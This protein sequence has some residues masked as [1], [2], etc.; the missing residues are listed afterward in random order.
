MRRAN[1]EIVGSRLSNTSG[2][3]YFARHKFG[4]EVVD[5]SLHGHALLKNPKAEKSDTAAVGGVEVHV[6]RSYC[7]DRDGSGPYELPMRI[8]TLGCNAYCPCRRHKPGKGPHAK[9]QFRPRR[10][11]SLFWIRRPP[12]DYQKVFAFRSVSKTKAT[13]EIARQPTSNGQDRKPRAEDFLQR[14]ERTPLRFFESKG[15]IVILRVAATSSTS[16]T[17]TTCQE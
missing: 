12:S 6:L 11:G 5:H 10:S 9:G 13:R 1:I 14:E 3:N 16:S 4:G 7:S 17:K 8:M 15:R 2:T